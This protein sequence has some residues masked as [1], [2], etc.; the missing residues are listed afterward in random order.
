MKTTGDKSK[1]ESGI[2]W[3]RFESGNVLTVKLKINREQKYEKH[4]KYGF[5]FGT[6]K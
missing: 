5:T 3:K 4:E 1:I 6:G 2:A